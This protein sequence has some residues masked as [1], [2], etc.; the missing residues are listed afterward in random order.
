MAR[1]TRTES[2]LHNRARVIAVA[3]EL[4]L[5]DGYHATS[6]AAVA[7]EAGFSTGVVYSN[8]S[9]KAELALIVL[10]D[11]QTEQLDALR[12]AL[13]G[14]RPMSSKLADVQAWAEAAL[15]SGW[16]RLELEFALD[17]RADSSLVAAEARRHE[18]AKDLAALALADVIPESITTLVPLD[19]V[20]EAIINFAFGVA[21]RRLIDPSVRVDNLAETLKKA[22][23]SLGVS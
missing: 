17:A 18:S 21:I 9:G 10:R 7:D 11:I 12:A 23:K 2:Q 3:R 15:E 20:A 13:V 1:L 8:F 22:L 4:F 14:R 5:R 19:V 16:S 6:L